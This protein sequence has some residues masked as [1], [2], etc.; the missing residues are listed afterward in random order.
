MLS[1]NISPNTFNMKETYVS[2]DLTVG[3]TVGEPVYGLPDVVSWRVSSP[4]KADRTVAVEE[5]LEE[6]TAGQPHPAASIYTP[7][8]IQQQLLKHLQEHTHTPR[9]LSDVYCH[10]SRTVKAN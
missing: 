2:R 3:D 4:S 5:L 1:D 7:I 6:G 10:F 9:W 8:S